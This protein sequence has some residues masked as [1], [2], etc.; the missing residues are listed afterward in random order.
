[1]FFAH[2]F[3]L[4]KGYA[5]PDFFG[6]LAINSGIKYSYLYMSENSFRSEQSASFADR[7]QARSTNLCPSP[8]IM[9]SIFSGLSDSWRRC[10]EELHR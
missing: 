6:S 10:C 9:A 8:S 1:M 7:R 3:N 2:L 4:L 5:I